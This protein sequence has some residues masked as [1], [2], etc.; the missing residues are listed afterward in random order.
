MRNNNDYNQR[1]CWNCHYSQRLPRRTGTTAAFNRFPSGE[2]GLSPG[3]SFFLL[4][5]KVTKQKGF[6]SF[7]VA[8]KWQRKILGVAPKEGWFLVTNLET[9]ESAIAAYKKRFD[10]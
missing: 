3:I 5:V 7:N 8:G 4:G 10:I 1:T 9:L 6:A 2:L